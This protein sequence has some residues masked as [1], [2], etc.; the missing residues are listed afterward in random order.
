M[1]KIKNW[2]CRNNWFDD[3]NQDKIKEIMR[4]LYIE[5]SVYHR[6]QD[7]LQLDFTM[8]SCKKRITLLTEILSFILNDHEFFF[9]ELYAIGINLR[10]KYITGHPN[11]ENCIEYQSLD[12]DVVPM[13]DNLSFIRVDPH[14]FHFHRFASDVMKN[15]TFI[16]NYLFVDEKHRLVIKAYDE[17]GMAIAGKDREYLRKLF[18][19][20]EKYISSVYYD[21]IKTNFFS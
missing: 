8:L 6:N 7:A 3:N 18:C 16:N 19:R 10:N 12:D 21:A 9:C 4:E 20:Y 15:S 14:T 11:K 5:D 1:H 2:M 17:R 13:Y